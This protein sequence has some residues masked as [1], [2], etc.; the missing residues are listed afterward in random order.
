MMD[1]SVSVG[2]PGSI[3]SDSASDAPSNPALTASQTEHRE[4]AT[5]PANPKYAG[6]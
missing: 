5:N 4:I 3:F 6:Y 1:V 2:E